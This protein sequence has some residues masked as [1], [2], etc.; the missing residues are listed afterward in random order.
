MVLPSISG[1]TKLSSTGIVEPQP[2]RPP[3]PHQ[4]IQDWQAFREVAAP[5]GEVS[6]E[7]M[8]PWGNISCHTI[9]RGLR[10]IA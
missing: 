8:A 3:L 10:K 2:P 1:A 5:H 4:K 7:A 9:G 6:T